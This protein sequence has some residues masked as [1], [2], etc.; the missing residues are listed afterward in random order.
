[1]TKKRMAGELLRAKYEFIIQSEV[2]LKGT[3]FKESTQYKTS[4][5]VR[6]EFNT[7]FNVR[8]LTNERVLSFHRLKTKRYI[9]HCEIVF[10]PF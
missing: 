7:K 10:S 9:L 4:R 6:A 3:I 1:M 8:P 5:I 2:T